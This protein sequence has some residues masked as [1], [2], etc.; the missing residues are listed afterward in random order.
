MFDKVLIANRGEIAC[1]IMRT[2]RAMGL[3]TVAVYSDADDSSMHMQMADEAVH[4]GPAAASESYL[5]ADNIL[6]A[7]RQTGAGAIHPGYGFL[8]ENAAFAKACENAGIAFIGPSAKA[9]AS[10]G[11]KD[12]AKVIMEAAGVPVVPGYHGAAQ[13]EKTLMAAAEDIGYPIL[14]KAVAGGGGKGM[15]LVGKA[16]EFADA[17]AS[18]K[19][20]A[21]S[22]FGNDHCLIEK[23]ITK[24]RHIEIQVFGDKHGNAVHLY[25]RDCS[26]QRRH[27]KVVEEAPAP[28]MDPALRQKM[29]DAAV[30]AAKAIGYAGA[31]TVEFIVDGSGPLSADTG[32]YFMEMNTRLQVEHPV[33]EMITGQDLVEWQLRVAAD[34]PLPLAQEDIPLEGHAMEVRLYAEDAAKGFMP[35]T[36][37]LVHFDVPDYLGARIDTGVR[38]GDEISIHYDPMI[39][40]V[41]VSGQTRD[42]ALS[43]LSS[44]LRETNIA[45]L[46]TNLTFLANVLDTDAFQNAQFDTGFIDA[47]LDALIA[48]DEHNDQLLPLAVLAYRHHEVMHRPVSPGNDYASPFDGESGWQLNLPPMMSEIIFDHNGEE[49]HLRASYPDDDGS[50]SFVQN[51]TVQTVTGADYAH[52]GVRLRANVD[53]EQVQATIA[54]SMEENHGSSLYLMANGGCEAFHFHDEHWNEADAA[55]GPG[56]LAAPMPGKIID[57]MAK[58][59]D[60]V[61]QDQPLLIMEAMKME[62]TLKAP[63]AGIIKD[64]NV[65]VGDQVADGSA[66][67]EIADQDD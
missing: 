18:A 56:T 42:E 50:I 37:K 14:I 12:E 15:R 53:G 40:K 9:I 21:K 34:E 59:G 19:R 66:V 16:G 6:N 7:A 41:I 55:A 8:S 46:K 27:Q 58:N 43:T 26:L 4:I 20:E 44:T 35:Q 63:R 49:Y 2:A 38:G 28:G 52:S 67:L 5:V 23:F 31:G 48:E 33:T 13:D 17:L 10:M 65:A 11:L 29:G 60:V 61:E 62:Y 1:R 3:K 24:P 54:W 22:A 32:F 64:L 36:G 51:G 45:G 30:A 39:A 47:H 25:E 57:V